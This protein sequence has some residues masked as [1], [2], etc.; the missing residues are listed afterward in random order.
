MSFVLG[1]ILGF[2]LGMIAMAAWLG[3]VKG[4]QMPPKV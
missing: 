3:L 1:F 4:T 2:I